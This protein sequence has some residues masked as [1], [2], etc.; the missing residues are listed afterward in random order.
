VTGPIERRH[1]IGQQKRGQHDEQQISGNAQ[2][3]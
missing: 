2:N 3:L 1:Q